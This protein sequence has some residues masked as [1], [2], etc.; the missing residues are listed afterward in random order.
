MDAFEDVEERCLIEC[1]VSPSKPSKSTVGAALGRVTPPSAPRRTSSGDRLTVYAPPAR[2]SIFRNVSWD[3][4]PTK[5]T[6]DKPVKVVIDTEDD[7]VIALQNR[8]SS[9]E[10]LVA[11]LE[12]ELQEYRALPGATQLKTLLDTANAERMALQSRVDELASAVKLKDQELMQLHLESLDGNTKARQGKSASVDEDEWRQ[13]H[14]ERDT[15]LMRAGELAHELAQSRAALDELDSNLVST[16]RMVGDREKEIQRLS[17]ELERYRA[18]EQPKQRRG[19]FRSSAPTTVSS[20]DSADVNGDK[21]TGE[22]TLMSV[23]AQMSDKISRLEEEK[24]K[25]QVAYEELQAKL[26]EM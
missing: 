23:I 3:G 11:D 9:L 4:S 16:Q 6:N 20:T 7:I 14:V 17:A 18:K 12:F 1:D 8:V 19:F 2:P 26:P 22:L 25:Y 10:E 24:S 21:C 13:L 5:R 15:A